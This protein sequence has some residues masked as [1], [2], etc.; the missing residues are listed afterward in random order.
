MRCFAR[1]SHYV[2]S[3][4][5]IRQEK[6][7]ARKFGMKRHFYDKEKMD[8]SALPPNHYRRELQE[9][10]FEGY[11]ENVKQAFSLENATHTEI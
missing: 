3:N 9:E 11:S 6:H 8:A 5:M 1:A 10:D 4:D 7:K 2:G